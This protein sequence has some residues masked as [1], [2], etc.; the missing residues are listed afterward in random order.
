MRVLSSVDCVTSHF[1]IFFH[2][3][4]HTSCVFPSKSYHFLHHQQQSSF[5]YIWL[6]DSIR[7]IHYNFWMA[8]SSKINS[9]DLSKGRYS[10]YI[11][12][13]A[14]SG[15][16]L[17]YQTT[18][19]SFCFQLSQMLL[20]YNYLQ[21]PCFNPTGSYTHANGLRLIAIK[22][23]FSIWQALHKLKVTRGRH[24]K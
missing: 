23:K 4:K 24:T 20:P 12:Q 11:W 6:S 3:K 16:D 21:I 18:K 9:T 17:V 22:T 19:Q 5:K 2:R 13:W 10:C 1:M 14:D 15:Q 7:Q 8:L